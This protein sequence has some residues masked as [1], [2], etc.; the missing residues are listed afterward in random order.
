MSYIVT[1]TKAWAVHETKE[2]AL[3]YAKDMF[4]DNPHRPLT[5][6]KIES[7]LEPVLTLKEKP[8]IPP[9]PRKPRAKK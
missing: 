2:A 1:P 6:S 4:R 9:R 5:I 7:L 8:Y 3:K